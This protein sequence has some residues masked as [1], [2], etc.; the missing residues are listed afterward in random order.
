MYIPPGHIISKWMIFSS[1]P[2]VIGEII[3]EN[4]SI[5]EGRFCSNHIFQTSH[6][7]SLEKKTTYM[8][9]FEKM[10]INKPTYDNDRAWITFSR[11]PDRRKAILGRYPRLP[12]NPPFERK[13]CRNRVPVGFHGFSKGISPRGFPCWVRSS[14][15]AMPFKLRH[16][17]W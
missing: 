2:N 12:Q 8:I 14:C 3:F 15:E 1:Y 4:S 9:Y 17:S 6:P 7:C 11:T 5:I 13:K 16:C 10:V